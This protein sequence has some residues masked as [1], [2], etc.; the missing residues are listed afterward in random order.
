[1]EWSN[2]ARLAPSRVGPS[3]ACTIGPVHF[4]G[5][6]TEIDSRAHAG[7]NP[8]SQ[9]WLGSENASCERGNIHIRNNHRGGKLNVKDRPDSAQYTG[10]RLRPE[11]GVL[12][13]VAG[14]GIHSSYTER[15]ARNERRV[16]AECERHKLWR[17]VAGSSMHALAGRSSHFYMSWCPRLYKP[18]TLRTIGSV[19]IPKLS[20]S[21]IYTV[22]CLVCCFVL[23]LQ[24]VVYCYTIFRSRQRIEMKSRESSRS[25]I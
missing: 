8:R 22:Y 16:R 18:L 10:L 1:M 25:T 7:A 19:C 5:R 12:V 23:L 9:H 4:P 13:I 14:A 15:E 6:S 2:I 11:A 3:Y 21:L 20:V 24:C 17:F